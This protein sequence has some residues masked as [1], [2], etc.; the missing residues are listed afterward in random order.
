MATKLFL[1]QCS[2]LHGDSSVSSFLD[3]GWVGTDILRRNS[4]DTPADAD[5]VIG[6]LFMVSDAG[7]RGY[8]KW[9]VLR[10]P[11][12]LVYLIIC[13]TSVSLRLTQGDLEQLTIVPNPSA[14]SQ[15]CSATR[16]PLLDPSLLQGGGEARERR[17]R[18]TK[19]RKGVVY[20]HKEPA[21]LWK[22][23]NELSDAV[24]SAPPRHDARTFEQKDLDSGSS[25]EDLYEGSGALGEGQYGEGSGCPRRLTSGTACFRFV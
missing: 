22:L 24:G 7:G 11:P 1:G 17:G 25:D 4:L 14:V 5:I 3:C 2:R 16:I 18:R 6:Y 23:T 20:D 13:T 12:L 15:Q 19:S 9:Q 8:S 10:S 21:P